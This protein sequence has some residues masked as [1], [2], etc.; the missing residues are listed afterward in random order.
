MN[1]SVSSKPHPRHPALTTQELLD[2]WRAAIKDDD[3]FANEV[4]QT[5][6]DDLMA[7]DRERTR[8]VMELM[9]RREPAARYAFEVLLTQARIRHSRAVASGTSHPIGTASH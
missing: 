8:G 4:I 2:L 9:V 7:F 5:V 1:G 6:Y 3:G